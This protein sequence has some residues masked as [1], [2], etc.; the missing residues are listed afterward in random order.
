MPTYDYECKDCGKKFEVHATIA[1][2]DK[3]KP[4]CPKCGGKKVAQLIEPFVAV[5]SKK[6]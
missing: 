3:Q 5:T 2:H 6:S 1:E 4:K